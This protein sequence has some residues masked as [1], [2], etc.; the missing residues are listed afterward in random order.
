MAEFKPLRDRLAQIGCERC[1]QP[2]QADISWCSLLRGRQGGTPFTD[3]AF[4]SSAFT[5]TPFTSTLLTATDLKQQV[6]GGFQG[7]IQ[8]GVS[9]FFTTEGCW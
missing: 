3:T 1:Q 8:A 9:E 6:F 7:Q 4:T 2:K 5:S